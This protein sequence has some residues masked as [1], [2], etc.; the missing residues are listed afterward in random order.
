[1][2]VAKTVL[3]NG[4]TILSENVPY[5][6]SATVGVWVSVGSRAESPP[7]NGI[8]HFIEHMLFKGTARRQAIDISREIE[9]VGGTMNA[10]TDREFLFFF[11]K[12]LT[13]DFPLVADLLSDIYLYSL[14]D[15]QELDREKG[16]VLQEILM[17]ED[18][19]E[20]L[21]HDFFHESYWGG[22]PLGLPIQGTSG[23]VAAFTRERVTEYFRDRFW[24]R[25]VIVSVVGNVPHERVV[26]E[27]E[28]VMGLLRLGERHVPDPPPV[29]RHAVF[30]KGRPIEQIH[31]CLGAPAVSRASEWKYAAHVLNAI[32]G[33]SM[34]SRLFQ[35]IREKR[36][37][38]YSVFSSLS[39]YADTGI[40]KICAGTTP[41][42]AGDVL[43]VTGEVLADLAAG[44]IGEEEVI[45]AKELIKGNMLLSME[46][47]EFRMTR[48]AV[49]E[50]FLGRLE[51]PEEEIRQVD[52]VTPERVK[53]L[54]ATL[55]RRECFSLAAVGDVAAAAA[56]SF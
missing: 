36:G 16:V 37:L 8:S 52:E 6:R 38:A 47:A 25:G 54:A 30:L 23:N 2:T 20:D 55:F 28:R 53:A 43:G 50:M 12:V 33:G 3:G 51:E 11:G 18:S 14:F 17:V 44:R 56:L 19:P 46:S 48:L 9:S 29:P 42:K 10:C 32:L 34:S 5:L 7:E 31:L 13:K 40:L 49:N 35:E 21:L 41:D 26:D 39:S 27:F 4:V 24:R 22:H 15:G 1:M 45:L